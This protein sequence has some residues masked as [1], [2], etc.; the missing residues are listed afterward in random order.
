MCPEAIGPAPPPTVSAFIDDT[1]SREAPEEN[2]FDVDLELQDDELPLRAILAGDDAEGPLPP[3]EDELLDL[4]EADA[5]GGGDDLFGLEGLDELDALFD[6]DSAPHAAA[7]GDDEVGPLVEEEA[8]TSFLE[9]DETETASSRADDE[10]TELDDASFDLVD[11]PPIGARLGDEAL[12]EDAADDGLFEP[13]LEEV[14]L[15]E[16]PLP[17]PAPPRITPHR[18]HD[19]S[20]PT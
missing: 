2:G 15:D 6:E 20:P 3:I 19:R 10:G 11:L 17:A 9:S 7:S 13:T 14:E 12:F 5:D 4:P 18:I 16:E 8:E 1:R